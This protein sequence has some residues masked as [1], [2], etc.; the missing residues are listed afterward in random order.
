MGDLIP[1]GM[2]SEKV[3]PYHQIYYTFPTRILAIKY[4]TKNKV[5]RLL[6]IT[7]ILN[8]IA[9]LFKKRKELFR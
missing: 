9:N 7:Y 1:F 6:F 2:V 5:R 4:N 8:Y 3:I